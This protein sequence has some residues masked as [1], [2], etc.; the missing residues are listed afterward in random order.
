MALPS[1]TKLAISCTWRSAP[2]LDA[3]L[4]AL[5][6]VAGK[7]RTDHDSVFDNQTS[8]DGAIAHPGKQY[9]PDGSTL[10]QITVDLKL[11]DPA[12]SSI[13][14]I[15]SL[16]GPAGTKLSHLGDINT[17][18]DGI[19][20][21]AITDFNLGGLLT[22]TAAVTVQLYRRDDWWQVRAVGQGD[23][24][25]LAGLT[26]YFGVTV[27]ESES[28]PNRAPSPLDALPPVTLT[29]ARPIAPA[30]SPAE[31]PPTDWT[32]PPVPTGY[33]I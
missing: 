30:A 17:R 28:T 15:V 27:Q 7:I 33:E 18:L 23:S 3:D 14:F 11:L 24:N 29:Q 20:G 31:S 22:E 26:R 12:V 8:L 9:R 6:L 5:L 19:D 1:L 32:R 21:A 2:P 13:M 16:A 10:D 4:S 25:G